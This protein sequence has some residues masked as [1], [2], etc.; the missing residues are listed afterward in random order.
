MNRFNDQILINA[1]VVS[2]MKLR[3]K[4]L[5]ALAILN[6]LAVF[7]IAMPVS[8]ADWVAYW[9][10]NQGNLFFYDRDG[11]KGKP[12]G[13]VQVREKLD[14]LR[15]DADLNRSGRAGRMQPPDINKLAYMI[16]LIELNCKEAK[17]QVVEFHDFDTAGNLI[18]TGSFENDWVDIN[19]D[20]FAAELKRQVCK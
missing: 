13:I 16:S 11:I 15:H 9:K 12:G 2:T 10:D 14:F 3:L 6:V 20:T 8:S 17:Y 1:S 4:I 18:S 5:Y 7:F 19:P